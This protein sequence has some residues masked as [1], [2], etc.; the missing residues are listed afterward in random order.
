MC[1]RS[2][3]VR[4]FKFSLSLT[5]LCWHAK[6]AKRGQPFAVCLHGLSGRSLDSF[7]VIPFLAAVQSAWHVTEEIYGKGCCPD[8]SEVSQESGQPPTAYHRPMD[9]S[10]ALGA[11]RFFV[12]MPWDVSGKPPPVSAEEASKFTLHR[13]KVCEGSAASSRNQPTAAG[14]SQEPQRP[15]LEPRRYTGSLGERTRR[16]RAL[17]RAT[18]LGT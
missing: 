16:V 9:Y 11:L 2:K 3:L 12:G 4:G 8:S 5:G 13:L 14:T 1:L 10:Q 15:V 18:P 6:T 7:W 17:S